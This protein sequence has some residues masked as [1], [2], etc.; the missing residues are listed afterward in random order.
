MQQLSRW[1]AVQTAG[2][3]SPRRRRRMLE[4]GEEVFTGWRG[5][6][7]RRTKSSIVFRIFM[8]SFQIVLVDE[9]LASLALDWDLFEGDCLSLSDSLGFVFHSLK[10][11]LN[12]APTQLYVWVVHHTDLA[13]F[14]HN[15]F[16]PCEN[17]C[18]YYRFQTNISWFCKPLLFFLFLMSVRL[19]CMG[20][21]MQH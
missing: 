5:L 14:Y 9:P 20:L 1:V 17:F 19:A 12:P 3:G 18:F 16:H 21:K 8:N 13:H 6:L 15:L 2:G 4:T 11:G 7:T 10:L